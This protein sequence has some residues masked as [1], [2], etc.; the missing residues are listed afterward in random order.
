MV[1]HF[2]LLPFGEVVYF[3]DIIIPY[4]AILIAMV[5]VFIIVFFTMMYATRKIK[6]ANIIDTIR[7][8]NI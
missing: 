6:K 5:S 8:E 1:C 4:K 3:S 7:E 2:H